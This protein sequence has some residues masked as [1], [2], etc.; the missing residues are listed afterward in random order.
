MS[1]SKEVVYKPLLDAGAQVKPESEQYTYKANLATG[2]GYLNKLSQYIETRSDPSTGGGDPDTFIHQYDFTL[3]NSKL[4]LLKYQFAW[5]TV[6]ANRFSANSIVIDVYVAG[7]RLFTIIDTDYLTMYQDRY[8]SFLN[9]YLA[10]DP[11][12][13]TVKITISGNSPVFPT[14]VGSTGMCV[15]LLNA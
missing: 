8:I 10:I 1:S 6:S 14:Y 12:V 2:V 5:D 11:V 15:F 9:D 13:V 7:V 4:L 3:Q